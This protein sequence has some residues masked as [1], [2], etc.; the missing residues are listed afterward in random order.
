MHQINLQVGEELQGI[1]KYWK[2]IHFLERKNK[3]AN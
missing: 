2:S 3:Y 1:P